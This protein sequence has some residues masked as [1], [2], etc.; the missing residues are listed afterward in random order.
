MKRTAIILIIILA[1]CAL[2]AFAAEGTAADVRIP[3][4]NL[5]R[6][7]F[8]G[9]FSGE[10][11]LDEMLLPRGEKGEFLLA[12]SGLDNYEFT[13]KQTRA[14]G[15]PKAVPEEYT[16]HVTTYLSDGKTLWSSYAEG[17]GKDGKAEKIVFSAPED[18]QEKDIP[19]TG[20]GDYMI[21]ICLCAGAAAFIAGLLLERHR[22]KGE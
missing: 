4:E 14:E 3:V 12:L 18:P 7:A 5:G 20:D 15:G 8:F 16:V 2:P 9:L 10:D 19:Q 11:M 13:V 1:L 21:Y 17:P 6:E 22:G